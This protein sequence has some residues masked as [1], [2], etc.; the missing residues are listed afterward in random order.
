ML[1]NNVELKNN[2]FC[3]EIHQT[4]EGNKITSQ[5]IFEKLNGVVF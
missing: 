3:D 5:L 1:K 2:Y 4:N